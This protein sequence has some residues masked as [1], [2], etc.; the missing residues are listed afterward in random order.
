MDGISDL[1]E[2]DP[3]RQACGMLYEG[4]CTQDEDDS[5]CESQDWR[6]HSHQ[7]F[8]RDDGYCSPLDHLVPREL[9]EEDRGDRRMDIERH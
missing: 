3:S 5:V 1:R 6:N 8:N 4:E 2:E 7:D 9:G